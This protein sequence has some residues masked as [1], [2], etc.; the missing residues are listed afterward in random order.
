M[1]Q[2]KLR[3]M[4]IKITQDAKNCTHLAAPSIVR[5]KKFLCALAS[6]PT[7]LSTDF[8]DMCLQKG[9]LQDEEDFLLKDPESEKKFGVKLKDAISRA[10]A[11]QRSLL[12]NVPI[13]CTQAIPNGTETYQAIVAA[14]GGHCLLYTGRPVVRE[15]KDPE[16]DPDAGEPIYLLTG[17]KPEERKLWASFEEMA[18]SGNMEPRVVDTEWL[19]DVVLLQK[20]QWNK[21]LYLAKNHKE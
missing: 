15:I 9:S 16:N 7:V 14:N 12:R 1:S 19:L 6:G 21:D 10:K 13:Y 11:N 4:G 5:T 17:Q 8:L 18:K 3:E 2:R 20:S